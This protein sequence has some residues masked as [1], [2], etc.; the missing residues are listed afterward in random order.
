MPG[1]ARG[2]PALIFQPGGLFPMPRNAALLHE[3]FV[4]GIVWML[5]RICIR[6]ARSAGTDPQVKRVSCYYDYYAR[7]IPVL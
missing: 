5:K 6:L 1:W 2:A 7:L 4:L 3:F